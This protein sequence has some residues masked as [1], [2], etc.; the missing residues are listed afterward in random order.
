VY[1]ENE[2]PSPE[3]YDGRYCVTACYIAVLNISDDPCLL[4]P[5]GEHCCGSVA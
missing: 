4:F 2:I 1:G 5:A 3:I